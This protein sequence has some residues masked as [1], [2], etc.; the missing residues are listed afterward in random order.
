MN[1]HLISIRFEMKDFL[2]RLIIQT[3]LKFSGTRGCVLCPAKII[4]AGQMWW[5]VRHL[6]GLELFPSE[7]SDC[8][9]GI[10]IALSRHSTVK[11]ET[12]ISL[13][14]SLFQLLLIV[15]WYLYSLKIENLRKKYQSH[16][17]GSWEYC[18]IH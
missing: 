14:K 6:C 1:V 17:N 7:P 16:L 10:L 5:L 4:L 3:K 18:I 13:I 8:W 15:D 2:S 11:R 12:S 9:G